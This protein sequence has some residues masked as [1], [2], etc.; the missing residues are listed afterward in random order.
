[1]RVNSRKHVL[2]VRGRIGRL[3]ILANARRA[4]PSSIKVGWSK[5]YIKTLIHIKSKTPII[6]ENETRSDSASHSVKT[7]KWKG[8]A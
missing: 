3:A 8:D 5:K 6:K 7:G 4:G 1:M 2:I